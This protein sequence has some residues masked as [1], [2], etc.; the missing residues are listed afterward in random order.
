MASYPSRRLSPHVSDQKVTRHPSNTAGTER[1]DPR[2]LAA[3]DPYGLLVL[4]HTLFTCAEQSQIVRLAMRHVS[5][6]G[7]YHAEAGYVATDGGLSRIPGNDVG[8]PAVDDAGMEDLGEAA[9]GHEDA[10]AARA[11]ELEAAMSGH[12]P[13]LSDL[14]AAL[15]ATA[16][17]G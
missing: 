7:P 16:A 13:A 9:S 1:H 4:T 15:E 2:P 5:A 12:L 11:T 6:L 8:A 14:R 17:L 3:L 10:L